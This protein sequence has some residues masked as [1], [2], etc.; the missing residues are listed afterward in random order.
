V[1]LQVFDRGGH[2]AFLGN[3]GNGGVHW[4]ERL[5]TDWTVARA[6]EDGTPAT[7]REQGQLVHGG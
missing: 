7:H 4:V 3:D 6:L 1:R 5:L 2:A